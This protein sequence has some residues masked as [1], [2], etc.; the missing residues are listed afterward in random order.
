MILKLKLLILKVKIFK[1][2]FVVVSKSNFFKNQITTL[3]ES[4]TYVKRL[5][6]F[7]VFEP[8]ITVVTRQ[9]RERK[10]IL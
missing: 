6:V 2:N 7:E 8:K 10:E 1:V 4:R 9:E 3:L 5:N